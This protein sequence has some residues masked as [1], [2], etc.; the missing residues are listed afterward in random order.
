MRS[1]PRFVSISALALGVVTCSDSPVA[2]NRSTGLGRISLAAVFSR[3]AAA[4]LGQRTI[5]PGVRYDH[6]RISVIRPPADT[7]RDTTITF[8]LDSAA[9]TLDLTVNVRSSDELFTG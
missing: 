6:V 2:A 4:A 1:L 3:E 7:V 8:G 9:V 5:F